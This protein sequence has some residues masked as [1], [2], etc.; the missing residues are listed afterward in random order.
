MFK[1]AILVLLNLSISMVVH[2]GTMGPVCSPGKVSLLCPDS[3]WDIGIQALY[4]KPAYSANRGYELT[5]SG[6][7]KAIQPEFN[8]GYRLE[9][10]Y[11]FNTG[12]D[13]SMTWIHYNAN[14]NIG[15]SAASYLQLTPGG[16]LLVDTIANGYLN[17]KLD[18]VNLVM[19]Q[20]VQVSQQNTT[21]FYAGMQ[22]AGIH[23][24][25]AHN[26]TV[27]PIFLASTEGVRTIT[28]NE[29]NGIGALV[30]IDYA[31]SIIPGFNLIANTAAAVLIGSAR[32][33]SSTVYGSGLSLASIYGSKKNIVPEFELK[34][35]ANYA[36][37]LAQGV[38]SIEGGY[39]ALNYLHALQALPAGSATLSNSDFGLYG[40]Y[41]GVKWLG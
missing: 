17:N 35:G 12:N 21:R 7:I 39:Q 13:I 40:P 4:L 30:G 26:F 15:L 20:Q 28:D 32:F 36:Y 23:I 41:F 10:S 33:D 25:G 27:P 29:F 5:V 8:W 24:N 37:T 22:Y 6:G 16:P 14:S 11:H 34:L 19:G 9:G 38:L 3:K 1:K 18:Q 31:Y 2:A